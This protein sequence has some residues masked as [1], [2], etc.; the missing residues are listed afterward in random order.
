[1]L[2]WRV[3]PLLATMA[4]LFL[5]L[6]PGG[7]GLAAEG[8]EPGAADV[9]R[10]E[11]ASKSSSFLIPW[12]DGP[13]K[14]RLDLQPADESQEFRG[15]SAFVAL[16]GGRVAVLDTL[17]HEVEVFDSKGE[18]VG[19][20]PHRAFDQYDAE[21]FCFDLA[22]APGGGFY[23]LSINDRAILRTG[24]EGEGEGASI[25]IRGL[26]EESMLMGLNAVDGG[27]LA[28]LDG[29]DNSVHVFD[30]TGKTI[31]VIEV[32]SAGTLVLDAKGSLYYMA[33]AGPND[34]KRF[35][36]LR[37]NPPR[38]PERIGTVAA[39]EEIVAAEV[40]GLDGRDNVY[41][42]IETGTIENT[43]ETYVYRFSR[44]GPTGAIKA[45]GASPELTLVHSKAVS[46]EGD[47]LAATYTPEGMRITRLRID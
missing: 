34:F 47:V 41:V 22:P 26:G 14:L 30:E 15:P 18:P 13:G 21:V 42:S 43:V 10:V 7:G 8:D 5:A 6:T 29:F 32:E 33:P 28:V 44:K 19:T 25:P 12:G 45:P 46:P 11:P 38:P 20:V 9:N 1:M 39:A 27:R 40:L 2:P 36:L 24:P 16:R 17:G 4:V 3:V 23:L 35:D 31:S 37:T